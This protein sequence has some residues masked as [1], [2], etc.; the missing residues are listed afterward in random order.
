MVRTR[1]PR[2]RAMP[3]ARYARTSATHRLVALGNP[4]RQT[5]RP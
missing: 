4:K 2:P 1:R 3:L 5:D